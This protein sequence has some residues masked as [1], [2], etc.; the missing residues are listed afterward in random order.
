[1][2]Q[3]LPVTFA[4]GTDYAAATVE[5]RTLDAARAE[6]ATWS[7][8]GVV[9]VVSGTYSVAGGVAMPDDGGY[10]QVRADA[11]LLSEWGIDPAQTDADVQAAAAAALM[12]YDPPTKTELDSAVSPLAL[13]DTAQ[14]ILAGIAALPSVEDIA[15]ES[16]E[17]VR[18]ELATELARIDAAVS[19]L[20]TPANV[21]DAQAAVIAAIDPVLSEPTT[22]PEFGVATF[23]QWVSWLAHASVTKLTRNKN[24]G[25]IAVRDSGDTTNIATA[26]T[27][28]DGTTFT[29][30]PFS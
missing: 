15:E 29:R 21:S 25:V 5:Y 19:T 4:L 9:E 20:A 3:I 8:T 2:S 26:Q 22:V 12:A 10:L 14:S 6:V 28:D 23:R 7:G 27:N 13:E 24:T 16:A 1:M 17:E 11:V 30:G 18:E